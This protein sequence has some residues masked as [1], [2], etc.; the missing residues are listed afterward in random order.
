M[1]GD[2]MNYPQSAVRILVLI[3]WAIT[4]PAQ[5]RQDGQVVERKVYVFPDF[6][7]TAGAKGA[8]SKQEYTAAL[9]GPFVMER[10][11]YESDGTKVSALVYRPRKASALLPISVFNRGGYIRGDIAPDVVPT[12][13]RLSKDGFIIVAP[14]YRGSDGMA[15]KD[16]VGGADLADLMNI[17]PVIRSIVNADA[18]NIFLYGESRGGMMVLQAIRDGFPAKAAATYG[19]FSDF[20]ALVNADPKL[21]RPLVNSLWPDYEARKQEIA[22]RRSA[23]SWAGQIVVPLLLMHGGA[24]RSVDP[25]QTLRL[26]QKLQELRKPYELIVFAGDNHTLTQNNALRD[27]RAAA[28]FKKHIK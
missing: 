10:I 19:A 27:A 26:A 7:K 3:L 14:L 4:A 11:I 2:Y 28:W 13:D 12:F 25:V 16:E 1:H 22:G 17:V 5:M 21:Y 15:G 24:D 8:F 23:I 20:D 18:E 6:E 9:N